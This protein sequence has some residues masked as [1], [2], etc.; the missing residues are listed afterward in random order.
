MKYQLYFKLPVNNYSVS[1]PCLIGLIK[2][3]INNDPLLT[4]KIILNWRDCRYGKGN[5]VDSIYIFIYLE[6]YYFKYFIK[7][8]K[9]I[10][11]Y[12]TWLDLIK[13]WH[14]SRDTSKSLIMEYIIETLNKDICNCYNNKDISLL[15][16]WIPSENS[17][18]DRIKQPRFII[19]LC[20]KL[21]NICYVNSNYLRIFRKTILSPL[22]A[23]LKLIETKLCNKLYYNIDYKQIPYI[24]FKKYKN[25]FLNNDNINYQKFLVEHKLGK[26]IINNNE[27]SNLT[28]IIYYYLIY[29]EKNNYV[30]HLWKIYKSK[31]NLYNCIS[32]CDTSGSMYGTPSEISI[33]ISSLCNH[34]LL[35]NDK[36]SIISNGSSLY[37]YITY[38]RNG[39]WEDSIKYENIIKLYNH[40]MYQNI[41]TI[42]IFTDSI[43]Y[44]KIN[45]INNI[46]NINEIYRSK[47]YRI[48]NII[49]WN[50]HGTNQTIYVDYTD[51]IIILS[52]YCDNFVNNLLTNNNTI[53]LILDSIINS[54]RYNDILI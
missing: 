36:L 14:Y 24:A 10:P 16:K 33:G 29:N 39:Y 7:I 38:L 48:P 1:I 40:P 22:R 32:V 46:S 9:L 19:E 45:D 5:N 8:F 54:S 49:Y 11:K 37:E 4:L 27:I 50:I 31:Y 43:I 44:S 35:F 47:N 23:K 52:G 25:V 21:F 42:Y 34:T 13:I 3:F 20:K 17:K 26:F 28:N 6:H 53:D 2:Q 12:G 41:N 15:V 51:N 30:E 18:W